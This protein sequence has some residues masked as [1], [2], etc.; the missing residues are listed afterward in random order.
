VWNIQSFPFANKNLSPPINN[1]N[2]T[3][4]IDLK[5][6]FLKEKAK[7]SWKMKG[8][9]DLILQSLI[10]R[11]IRQ[12]IISDTVNSACWEIHKLSEV[13]C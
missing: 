7:I 8:I 1:S 13:V 2:P 12:A 9:E 5:S 4:S 11:I 3:V 10:P 6:I